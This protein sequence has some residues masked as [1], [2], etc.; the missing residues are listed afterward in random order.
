MKLLNNYILEKLII[1]K[2]LKPNPEAK[3]GNG[4]RY[5]M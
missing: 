2:D 1:N 5:I 4:V 3:L